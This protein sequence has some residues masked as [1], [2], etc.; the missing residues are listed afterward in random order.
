MK[1]LLSSTAVSTVTIKPAVFL[2]LF[3]RAAKEE[4]HVGMKLR[5]LLSLSKGDVNLWDDFAN[6]SEWNKAKR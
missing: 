3:P 5:L 6:V 1:G 4:S 2:P